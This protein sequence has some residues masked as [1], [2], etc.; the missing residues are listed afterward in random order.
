MF[1]AKEAIFMSGFISE[2]DL[3][4]RIMFHLGIHIQDNQ[5]QHI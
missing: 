5:R 3:Q 4:Q 2:N 1:C